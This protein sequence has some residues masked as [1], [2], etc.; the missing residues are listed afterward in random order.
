LRETAGPDYNLPMRIEVKESRT[1]FTGGLLTLKLDKIVLPGAREAEREYVVFGRSVVM[2]PVTDEGRVVLVNQYRHP[3]G[4]FI[5]ELPAGKVEEGESPTEAA[6][7]ELTEETGFRAG[8]LAQFGEFYLAPGYSTELMTG[9][10][11]TGLVP[12]EKRPDP[13]E[14]LSNALLTRDE[15]TAGLM[16]ARFQ[17]AKTI[18]GLLWWMNEGP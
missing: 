14:I 7:R 12:G 16:E 11:A 9:F 5:L 6:I 4:G 8:N 13:D 18:L 2:V 10:V 17:D 1:I 15:V 3:T